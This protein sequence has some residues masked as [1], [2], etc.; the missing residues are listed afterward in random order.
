MIFWHKANTF[1]PWSWIAD[2]GGGKQTEKYSI[3][4]IGG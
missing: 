3:G 1:L 2:L 4:G